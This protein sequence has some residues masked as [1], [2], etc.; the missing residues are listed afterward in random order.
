MELKINGVSIAA[1]PSQLTIGIYD[2]DDADSSVRGSDGTLNRDRIAVKRKLE[3][4]WNALEWEEVSSVLSAV[5][6]VFFDVYYPDPESGTYETKTF[7]VGD[8]TM[9][10]AIARAD[11]SI[12]WLGMS[13]SLIER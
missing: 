12:V 9:P 1:F 3:M 10:V 7:Y 8:R 13:L 5:K 6:N 2:L 11:G 4:S